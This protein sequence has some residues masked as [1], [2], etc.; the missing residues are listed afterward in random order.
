MDEL[1]QLWWWPRYAAGA[2]WYWFM[3]FLDDPAPLIVNIIVLLCVLQLVALDTDS[4]KE[5]EVSPANL[6]KHIRSF[7]DQ[8]YRNVRRH[9][10]ISSCISIVVFVFYC[11]AH[12]SS[13]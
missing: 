7:S 1:Y 6:Q 10:N 11:I 4:F 8:L 9:A 12:I 3:C 13:F 5:E 2:L